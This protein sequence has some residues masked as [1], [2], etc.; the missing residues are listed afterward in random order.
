MKRA[1]FIQ[2]NIELNQEFRFAD[3]ET[4][5]H[6][7]NIYNMSFYGSSLWDLFG[8]EIDSLLKTFNKSIRI[9]WDI[10][11]ET[12][13][14]LIEP[15]CGKPHLKFLLFK[16]FLN[17]KQQIFKSSKIA[18]KHL[19]SICEKDC[20]SLTGRNLTRIML[21]CGKSS[22]SSLEVNDL[23]ALQYSALP[24]GEEWRLGLTKELIDVRLNRMDLPG[25]SS[26][27]IS[28]LLRIACVS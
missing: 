2:R 18:V 24:E 17:F 19:Y 11:L 15:L 21:L 14:Y 5:Y 6:L 16:R 26:N 9:L 8:D 20:G 23:C 1:I 28:D 7:N 27:E 12:H 4:K 3:P 25:F 10:P 22:V 13:R